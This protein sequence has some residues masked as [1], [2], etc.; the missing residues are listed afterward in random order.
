[1]PVAV[2]AF[3]FEIARRLPDSLVTGV[4]I[5]KELIDRNRLI[6]EKLGL[7]LSV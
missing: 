5:D 7:K 2:R 6:A 1:M 3:S 4:D